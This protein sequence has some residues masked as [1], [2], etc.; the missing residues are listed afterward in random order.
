MEETIILYSAEN[1]TTVFN[2]KVTRKMFSGDL[3]LRP[4]YIHMFSEDFCGLPQPLQANTGHLLHKTYG[5]FLVHP[6]QMIKL[7]C[8]AQNGSSNKI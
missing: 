8:A 6:L 4:K 1:T 7:S 2:H 3:K 5:H